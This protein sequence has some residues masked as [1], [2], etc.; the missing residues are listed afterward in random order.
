MERR[1]KPNAVMLLLGLASVAAGAAGS[2]EKILQR[3]TVGEQALRIQRMAVQEKRHADSIQLQNHSKTALSWSLSSTGSTARL[4]SLSRIA[5]SCAGIGSS[6]LVHLR[7]DGEPAQ[8]TY[9]NARCGD[10]LSL[11]PEQAP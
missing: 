11:Q 8:E 3:L 1:V 5:I 6:Q 2:D 7:F 4:P 9:L 10:V